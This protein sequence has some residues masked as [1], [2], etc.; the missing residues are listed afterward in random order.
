MR[1]LKIATARLLDKEFGIIAAREYS[2]SESDINSALEKQA[3]IYQK[4]QECVLIGDILIYRKQLTREDVNA[5]LSEQNRSED[6]LPGKPINAPPPK[7]DAHPGSKEGRSTA[8]PQPAAP[9]MSEPSIEGIKDKRFFQIREL[10]KEFG[11][12]VISKNLATKEEVDTALQEQLSVY[13]EDDLKPFLGKILVNKGVLTNE[14]FTAIMLGQQR[15]DVFDKKFGDIAIEKGFVRKND[16]KKA[17]EEQKHILI[18][19]GEKKLIGDI[20]VSLSVISEGQLKEIMAEQTGGY[21]DETGN[22]DTIRRVKVHDVDFELIVS[23][24]GLSAFLKRDDEIPD[25]ISPTDIKNLLKEKKIAYGVADDSLIE[26]FLKHPAHKGKKFKIAEGKPAKKG[27][28]GKVNYHFDTEFL[29]AGSVDQ[30]GNID[31]KDRGEIPHVPAG[32]LLA[33]KISAIHGEKGIDVFGRPVAPPAVKDAKLKCGPGTRVSDD[34]LKLFAKI[35]GQPSL[36]FGGK[37]SVMSNLVIK[38]DIGLKTGHIDFDGNVKV[39]GAVQSGFK[40]KAGSLDAKEIHEAEVIASEDVTVSGGINGATITAGGIISAKYIAK[41]TISSFGDVAA[42]KE[43]IDSIIETSGSVLV[44]KGKIISSEIASKKGIESMDIGTDKSSPCKLKVGV[45]THGQREIQKKVMAI[46]A[47]EKERMGIME[48]LEVLEKEE[49]T[50]NQE[51][52][53]QAQ[54]QDRSMVEQRGLKKQMEALS[55][56]GKKEGIAGLAEQYKALEKKASDADACISDL[57]SRQDKLSDSKAA[58]L[59]EVKQLDERMTEL[60]DEKEDIQKWVAEDTP[61]PVVKARGAVYERSY[62]S[63]PKA[64]VTLD[65]TYKHLHIKELRTKDAAGSDTWEMK[66]IIQKG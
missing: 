38:G 51:I 23:K 3:K 18:K 15:Y 22:E 60:K 57:F 53:E 58:F 42:Q 32:E 64:S 37:I 62:I 59:K 34:N 11:K 61:V 12:I 20:L 10:D 65:K 14:Q 50:L 40:V 35:E 39:M 30:D 44:R 33:E 41:T 36:A 27:R 24:D 29:K 54:I 56:E 5:I 19:T 26:G 45:D 9:A 7:T 2:V 47:I 66:A 6:M 43:I 16:I 21:P 28:N 13:K 46:G 55:G 4:S 1:R 63:G 31:Y 8:D 25:A 17:L 49:E 48:Q 52:A